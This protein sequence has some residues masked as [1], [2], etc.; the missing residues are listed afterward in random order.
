MVS[1]LGGVSWGTS[2]QESQVSS[3]ATARLVGGNASSHFC[4]SAGMQLGKPQPQRGAR[5]PQDLG[6]AVHSDSWLLGLGLLWFGVS[7]A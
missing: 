7:G 4:Q 1:M 3:L 6:T 5:G 2:T